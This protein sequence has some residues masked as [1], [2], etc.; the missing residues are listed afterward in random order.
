MEKNQL[1][2]ELVQHVKPGCTSFVWKIFA[3]STQPL[4]VVGILDIE[5]IMVVIFWS[6]SSE[7]YSI[8]VASSLI[9]DLSERFWK[10]VMNC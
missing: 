8:R 7:K 1:G 4:E 2:E 3:W 10:S 5:R 6:T 9:L